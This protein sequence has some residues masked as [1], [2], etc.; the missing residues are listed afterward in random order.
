MVRTNPIW[1]GIMGH[2]STTRWAKGE[3]ILENSLEGVSTLRWQACTIYK[4][5]SKSFVTMYN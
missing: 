3:G 1:K 5:P 2:I 4:I